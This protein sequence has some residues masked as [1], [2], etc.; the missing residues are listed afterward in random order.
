MLTI[1]T[2]ASENEVKC[3]TA[4]VDDGAPGKDDVTAKT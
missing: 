4:N 1:L 3:V 2:P